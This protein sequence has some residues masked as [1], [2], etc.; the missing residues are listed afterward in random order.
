MSC[1]T[2]ANLCRLSSPDNSAEKRKWYS[3]YICW[4]FLYY[5][6]PSSIVLVTNV[7][8][9]CDKFQWDCIVDFTS[10]RHQNRLSIFE[11]REDIFWIRVARAQITTNHETFLAI[12]EYQFQPPFSLHFQQQ[13]DYRQVIFHSL[14]Q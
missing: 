1:A 14:Q 5:F 9:V 2:I 6:V 8:M 10:I 7:C 3:H 4:I 12:F 13:F 11:L